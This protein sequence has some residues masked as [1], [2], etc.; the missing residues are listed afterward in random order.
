MNSEIPS[1]ISFCAEILQHEKL[2]SQIFKITLRP[3]EP[4]KEPLPGQFFML[5]VSEGYDPFLRRPLSIYNFEDGNLQFLYRIRGRGTSILSNK[6]IGQILSLTGP[7]GRPYPEP[8]QKTEVF[9][10]AGGLGIASINYLTKRLI[11]RGQRPWLLYGAR[12][13]DELRL[14]SDI[15]AEGLHRLFTITE[16]GS[17]PEKGTVI[18]L[19]EKC[20]EETTP[21]L[22]YA[23]GPGPVLKI[24][25][26]MSQ[27]IGAE[28]YLAV[29]ERMACGIGV[30]L[31]C[32]IKTKKGYRRVCREGPVF[33]E[34]EIVW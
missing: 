18:D 19:L 33:R 22:I 31:G 34:G 14:L 28:A 3:L 6:R 4:L 10:V 5:S 2:T 1:A 9:I 7:F 30:C 15:S 13:R 25:D 12:T 17:G 27:N 26:E 21:S 23:C 20:L 32:A 29:E 24:V 16:D 8:A 11:M